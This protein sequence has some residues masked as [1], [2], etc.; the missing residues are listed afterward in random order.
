MPDNS[1]ANKRIAKNTVMLYLRMAFLLVISLYTSRVVLATLGEVDYGLFNVI[2]GVIALLGFLNTSMSVS[3]SR[4]I[5]FA[6]GKNDMKNQ[7]HVFSTSLQIHFFIAL[8]ILLIGETVGLWF[9]S[10]KLTIPAD[11]MSAAFWV[12]QCSIATSIVSVISVPYNATIIAHEKM[13]TFAYIS[14]YEAVAKLVI[15]YLLIISP[16]DK[17][18]LYSLLYFLVQLSVRFIYGYYCKSRFSATKYVKTKDYDLFKRMISFAGWSLYGSGAVALSNQGTNILLNIFYG[19]AVNAACGIAYQVRGVLLNFA[20]NFQTALNPQIIKTYAQKDMSSMYK[21]IDRST[22]ISFFLLFIIA[23]PLLMETGELLKLWLKEV[24]RY[25]DVFL[26]LV[27]VASLVDTTT[28]SLSISA[29]ATGKVKKY[30]L[31]IGTIFIMIVPIS[32]VALKLGFEASVVFV[33]DVILCSIILV[34]RIFLLYHLIGLDVNSYLKSLLSILKV[35]LVSVPIAFF[36]RHLLPSSSFWG[37][38]LVCFI[39]SLTVTLTAYIFGI[40]KHE[41]EVINGKIKKIVLKR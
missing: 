40:E 33:V 7:S 1:S 21:L 32:Y 3:T 39:C 34:A 38:I 5:T 26:Q 28:N 27:I 25:T 18:I 10:N 37:V 13:S 19:P 41:R 12:Y 16:F 2:G 24:P 30:Y 15:V 14:I 31:T 6:L 35:I 8:V 20:F 36:A 17:L 23:L 22:R 29:L 9:V 4:F 11:R